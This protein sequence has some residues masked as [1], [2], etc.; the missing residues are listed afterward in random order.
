MLVFLEY[1]EQTVIGELFSAVLT[2]SLFLINIK[3]HL[4]ANV[5]LCDTFFHRQIRRQ[6]LGLMKFLFKLAMPL[7]MK[8]LVEAGKTCINYLTWY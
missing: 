8:K 7:G 1:P 4:I 5:F 3:M 2:E 6:E